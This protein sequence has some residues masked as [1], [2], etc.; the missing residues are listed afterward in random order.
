MSLFALEVV[1]APQITNPDAHNPLG[2]TVG[3]PME[4]YETVI[5]TYKTHPRDT[6]QVKHIW[7]HI[8]TPA[9]IFTGQ[10]RQPITFR[11]HSKWLRNPTILRGNGSS[12]P[13]LDRPLRSS[14]TST[15]L[16]PSSTPAIGELAQGL[17]SSLDRWREVNKLP[18]MICVCVRGGHGERVAIK[19]KSAHEQGWVT[20][21]HL[22]ERLIAIWQILWLLW[23][24]LKIYILSHKWA[25]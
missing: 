22:P 12:D 6:K 1:L 9:R 3:Y 20:H 14:L 4:A 13:C 2:C 25:P 17:F 10:P 23:F 16:L 5:D 18:Q 15:R 21:T 7:N 11:N 8:K 24:P 19:F